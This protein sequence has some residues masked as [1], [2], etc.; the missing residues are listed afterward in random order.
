MIRFGLLLLLCLMAA[1]PARAECTREDR[2][3][4][5]RGGYDIDDIE[6]VCDL[7]EDD[8]PEPAAGAASYCD[9]EEGFCP[10]SAPAAVG[11]PCTCPTQ[12]GAM[13]GVTE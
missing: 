8:I 13:P 5:A 10:L 7:T 3:V 1:A 4:L 11:A 12:Y 9:T 2:G 6:A